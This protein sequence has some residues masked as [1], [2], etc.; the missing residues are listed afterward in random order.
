VVIGNQD[1]LKHG[2]KELAFGEGE[3]MEEFK[4]RVE[5]LVD[6]SRIRALVNNYHVKILELEG[7]SNINKY[8]E[9]R[10]RIWRSVDKEAKRIRGHCDECSEEYLKS[11]F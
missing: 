6:D 8:E 2:E 5:R 3:M 4:K 1:P 9:E 11:H 10:K 7:N